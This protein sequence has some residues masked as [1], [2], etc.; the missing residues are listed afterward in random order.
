VVFQGQRARRDLVRQMRPLVKVPSSQADS[1]VRDQ[2]CVPIPPARSS[3]AYLP[4]EANPPVMNHINKPAHTIT[5]I[6]TP[7][8]PRPYYRYHPRYSPMN[9]K[10]KSRQ[11]DSPDRKGLV[12][13]RNSPAEQPHDAEHSRK[14]LRPPSGTAPNG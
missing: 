6:G 4:R 13:R 8:D 14:S 12:P 9:Q 11:Y 1:P 5:S 7:Q 2:P 10:V 3:A